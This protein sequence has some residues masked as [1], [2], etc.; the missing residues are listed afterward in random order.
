MPS[1]VLSIGCFSMS[2][3][4]PPASSITPHWPILWTARH[5]PQRNLGRKRRQTPLCCP[6]LYRATWL[7][8]DMRNK[9]SVVLILVCLFLLVGTVLSEAQTAIRVGAFPNITHP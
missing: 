8:R 4:Q 3:T 1:T 5:E 2:V 6:W 7:G 9:G